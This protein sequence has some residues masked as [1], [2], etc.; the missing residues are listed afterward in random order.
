MRNEHCCHHKFQIMIIS[1]PI[2]FRSTQPKE[3]KHNLL[4]MASSFENMPN[5]FALMLNVFSLNLTFIWNHST[6]S[7]LII[8]IWQYFACSHVDVIVCTRFIT[9]IYEWADN[10][11]RSYSSLS[12]M[13]ILHNFTIQ[14]HSHKLN[15]YLFNGIY[16][17]FHQLP[18]FSTVY[19]SR[20]G[21]SVRW[22]VSFIILKAKSYPTMK[23]NIHYAH[24]LN[25]HSTAGKDSI[26]RMRLYLYYNSFK[27]SNNLV[28]GVFQ[29]DRKVFTF[30]EDFLVGSCFRSFE[31]HQF[32]LLNRHQFCLFALFRH[33]DVLLVDYSIRLMFVS[34][35]DYCRPWFEWPIFIELLSLVY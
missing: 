34:M 22:E 13:E 19:D 1:P 31:S 14:N 2:L 10:A 17:I 8:S 9:T 18:P 6:F 29:N 3:K 23:K 26:E 27:W 15:Q 21:M 32:C 16:I 7:L 11:N 5:P 20:A 4:F 24:F 33:T 35:A 28:C 12:H 25:K 30:L